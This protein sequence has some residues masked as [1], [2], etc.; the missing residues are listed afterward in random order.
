[1]AARTVS[2]RRLAGRRGQVAHAHTVTGEA[3]ARRQAWRHVL[4]RS[5]GRPSLRAHSR[6]GL[7]GVEGRRRARAAGRARRPQQARSG[8]R[9]AAPPSAPPLARARPPSPHPRPPRHHR[10]RHSSEAERDGEGSTGARSVC[11]CVCVRV[12]ACVCEQATGK[13][14]RMCVRTSDRQDGTHATMRRDGRGHTRVRELMAHGAGRSVCAQATV[15]VCAGDRGDRV[16]AAD[17]VCTGDHVDAC[18]P[19]RRIVRPR[20]RPMYSVPPQSLT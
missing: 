5:H 9:P 1:M 15:I 7:R 20:G 10:R 11:V 13:S 3:Q 6:A 16:C 14:A 8:P 4:T 2:R 12:C 19:L 17:R 18:S